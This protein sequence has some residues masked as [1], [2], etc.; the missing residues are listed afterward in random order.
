M[1]K[2][3]CDVCEGEVGLTMQHKPNVNVNYTVN[4]Y[5][6]ETKRSI[7]SKEIT[8]CQNCQDRVFPDLDRNVIMHEMMTHKD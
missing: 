6:P 2:C 8:C 3:F 1:I 4:S 7:Y 5:I